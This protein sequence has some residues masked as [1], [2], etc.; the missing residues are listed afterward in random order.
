MSPDAPNRMFYI[1][2]QGIHAVRAACVLEQL[3][4]H[5]KADSK[6][7]TDSVDFHCSAP[8]DTPSYINF[9]LLVSVRCQGKSQRSPC[10]TRT[11]VRHMETHQEWTPTQSSTALPNR[12]SWHTACVCRYRKNQHQM[13]HQRLSQLPRTPGPQLLL[14]CTSHNAP[15]P[16]HSNAPAFHRL[17]SNCSALCPSLKVATSSL[18]YPSHTSLGMNHLC[19]VAHPHLAPPKSSSFAMTGTRAR[20]TGMVQPWSPPRFCWN[21]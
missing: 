17:P 11:T 5:R 4:L 16:H 10:A 12:R 21:A 20:F 18:F 15:L 6:H 8:T 1:R 13:T 7:S 2:Y 19:C 3:R 14:H 9:T